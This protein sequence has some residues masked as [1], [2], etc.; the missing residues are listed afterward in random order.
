ML[1]ATGVIY[2]VGIAAIPFVSRVYAKYRIA[3]KAE[4]EEALA[5][6]DAVE[7]EIATTARANEDADILAEIRDALTHLNRRR[8]AA[9]VWE[10]DTQLAVY[11]GRLPQDKRDTMEAALARMIESRDRW[12]QVI[13]AKTSAALNLRQNAPAVAALKE[14]LAVDEQDD[15]T[16]RFR[17]EL[18]A[19]IERLR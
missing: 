1:T 9:Q 5:L 8:F 15:A 12:L 10:I 14:R 17:D 16:R 3:K 19:A 2:A 4:R 13:G 11:Y 7:L 18:E 6:F